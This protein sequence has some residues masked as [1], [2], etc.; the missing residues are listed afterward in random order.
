MYIFVDTS[1]SLQQKF[2]VGSY[3]IIYNLDG[4]LV[5]GG[6]LYSKNNLTT[7]L[8]PSTLTWNGCDST[9]SEMK[10][11]KY[12]LELIR[13]T[14]YSSD[15]YKNIFPKVL[16]TDCLQ[17]IRVLKNKE[18][19]VENTIQRDIIDLVDFTGVDV[20]WLKGHPKENNLMI[21]DQIF[22][23]VDKKSKNERKM[24]E[25]KFYNL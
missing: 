18:F 17:I 11:V 16:Y 7:P 15:Y 2:S 1:C 22:K 3:L 21:Q 19:W 14:L 25:S 12:V 20:K 5:L 9:L 8:S 23:V 6:R 10:T 4:V 13:E 24:I